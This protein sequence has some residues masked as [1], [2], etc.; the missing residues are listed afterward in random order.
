[1]LGDAPAA[2]YQFERTGH[3]VNDVADWS[4]ERRVQPD[5]DAA[6]QLGKVKGT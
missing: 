3:F 2:R 6:R 1:V 4:D 5:R